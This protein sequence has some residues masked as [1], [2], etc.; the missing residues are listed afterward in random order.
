VQL[1]VVTHDERFCE[2][3]GSQTDYFWRISK[4][5]DGHSVAQRCAMRSLDAFG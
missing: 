3:I 4:S 5:N 2:M 1:I